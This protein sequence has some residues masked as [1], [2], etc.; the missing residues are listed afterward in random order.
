MRLF[1]YLILL[2][3]LAAPLS[4]CGKKGDLEPPPGSKKTD[5][6]REYPR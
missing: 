3:A 5:Y 6:P 4:A 1:A 2:C